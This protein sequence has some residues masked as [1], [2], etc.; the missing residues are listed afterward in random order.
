MRLSATHLCHTHIAQSGSRQRHP[1]ARTHN[2]YH[3]ARPHTTGWYTGAPP[4]HRQTPSRRPP[5][6]LRAA[7]ARPSLAACARPSLAACLLI[8]C[9]SPPPARRTPRAGRLLSSTPS[10]QLAL[11]A[12]VDTHLDLGAEGAD[13]ALHGPRGGVAQGADGV[14]LNLISGDA[15][16]T[17]VSEGQRRPWKVEVWVAMGRYGEMHAPDMRAPP[18]YQSP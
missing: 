17:K 7:S 15:R 12:L 9:L 14:A 1:S 18:A 13:E 5:R 11:L 10:S 6:G 3:G 4:A 8:A 2:T 16:E